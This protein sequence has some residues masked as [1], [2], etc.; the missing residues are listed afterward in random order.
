[1]GKYS[2]LILVDENCKIIEGFKYLIL[3][4]NYYCIVML[5]FNYEVLF[6]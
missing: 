3:N 1:M 5:G 2:N 6:I 4:M